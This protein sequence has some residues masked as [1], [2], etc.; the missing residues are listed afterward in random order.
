MD[1]G[2]STERF[3][4]QF[5]DG[6]GHKDAQMY[7]ICQQRAQ[8]CGEKTAPWAFRIFEKQTITQQIDNS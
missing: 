4:K 7:V 8:D 6:T 5:V 1:N 3:S 2:M